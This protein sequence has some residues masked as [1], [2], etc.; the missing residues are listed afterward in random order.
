MDIRNVTQFSTFINAH[1]LVRLDGTF[2]QIITCIQNFSSACNCY[3]KQEK[4]NI[5]SVCNKLYMNAARHIVPRFKNEFL[6][7]TNERQ[8]AI[9]TENGNLMIILSR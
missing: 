5:Y 3:K 9:Y 1:N 6:S 7:K 4:D 8:I 2:Q